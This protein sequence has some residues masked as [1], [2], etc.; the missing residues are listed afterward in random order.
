MFVVNPL[1]RNYRGTTRFV[2]PPQIHRTPKG[3]NRSVW[4]QFHFQLECSTF[5]QNPQAPSP[6][7]NDGSGFHLNQEG[8]FWSF[9]LQL[10]VSCEDELTGEALVQAWS[11]QQGWKAEL[12]RE[13]HQPLS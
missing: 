8:T 3:M 5:Q 10:H 7:L 12:S 13:Y 6:A 2:W 4:L 11:F 1:M 9:I